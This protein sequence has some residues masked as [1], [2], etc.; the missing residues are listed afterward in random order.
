MG[1]VADPPGIDLRLGTMFTFGV[2]VAFFGF[3]LAIWAEPLANSMNSGQRRMGTAS[4]VNRT[5]AI[6]LRIAG[7]VLAIVGGVLAFSGLFSRNW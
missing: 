2:L 5:S 7:V 6:A 4:K 3:A 1:A